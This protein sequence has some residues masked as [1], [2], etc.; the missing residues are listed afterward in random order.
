V[1]SAHFNGDLGGWNRYG[2]WLE[3]AHTI[4]TVGQAAC[5]KMRGG[6]RAE[7]AG[8]RP[9]LF[10]SLLEAGGEFGAGDVQEG[11]DGGG[12]RAPDG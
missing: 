8:A 10:S 12:E 9:D 7:P 4:F 6:P 3:S 11:A 5:A 2:K 1:I